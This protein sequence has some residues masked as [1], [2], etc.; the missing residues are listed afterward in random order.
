MDAVVCRYQN[1]RL[2][3]DKHQCKCN[4]TVPYTIFYDLRNRLPKMS[5]LQQESP[6]LTL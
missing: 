5:I 4:A 2:P 6:Y 1:Y 3:L